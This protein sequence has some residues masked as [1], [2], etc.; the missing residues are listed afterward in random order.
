MRTTT[1][2][3]Y[4]ECWYSDASCAFETIP[5]G[6]TTHDQVSLVTSQVL[7]ISICHITVRIL[8]NEIADA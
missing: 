5:V 7:L 6:I 4:T 3:W 1:P 8:K 2:C